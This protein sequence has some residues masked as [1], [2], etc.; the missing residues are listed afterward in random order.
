MSLCAQ[1]VANGADRAP[2][3]GKLRGSDSL[4]DVGGAG[5]DLI[6]GADPNAPNSDTG[7]DVVSEASQFEGTPY[8]WGG[9]APGV[10]FDCSGLVQA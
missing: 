10:G 9:E 6:D 7:Q 8:V 2:S 3:N 5:D 1:R 4:D